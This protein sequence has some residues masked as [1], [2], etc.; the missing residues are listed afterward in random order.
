MEKFLNRKIIYE[1]KILRLELD[2]VQC[3]NGKVSFREIVRHCGGAAIL[4]ISP[5]NKIL[6][7]KQYRYAYNEELLEIPAGKLEE[8]EDFLTAAKREFEEETGYLAQNLSYLTTIYPTCGYSS[9]KIYLCLVT[10]YIPSK[11]NLDEDECLE[12]IWMDLKEVC[13]KIEEGVIKDAK[14][15]C[16]IQTYLIKMHKI[17]L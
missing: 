10:K 6:L 9:E 13:Q 3:E 5:E 14:T 12:P 11:Q 8:N 17:L 2:Q 16:A 7:V 4:C 1:G 15:I